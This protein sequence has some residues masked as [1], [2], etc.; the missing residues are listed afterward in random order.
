MASST[1]LCLILID[2]QISKPGEIAIIAIR[3]QQRTATPITGISANPCEDDAKHVLAACMNDHFT[4][5]IAPK[6][7]FTVILVMPGTINQ[8]SLNKSKSTNKS[9]DSRQSKKH[10]TLIAK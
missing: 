2:R 10:M 8:N 7:L 1:D 3:T 4:K 5:P 9:I 6:K